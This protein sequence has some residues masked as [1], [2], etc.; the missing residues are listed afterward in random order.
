M[1]HRIGIGIV[2]VALVVVMSATSSFATWS[3][4]SSGSGSSV[5]R[6][7]GLPTAALATAAGSASITITWAAPTGASVTPTQYVVR[8]TA[9]S[10]A[11]VCTVGGGV[12]TCSDTGLSGGTTYTYTVE[13]RIG[14]N[15]TSGQT[16]GTS[17]T[18]TA[19]GNFLVSVSGTKTAGTA[20]SPTITATTNGVATDTSYA[21][22]KTITFSGP[23]AS[24]SGTNPTYPV[25]VTFTA[26]VG[27]PS[28]TLYNAAIATLSVTDGTISGSTS[29]TVTSG[30]ATQLG[31]TTSTPS[32][33]AGTVA[34]GN[35]G[36]FTSRVSVYDAYLN[37]FTQASNRT[38]TVSRSPII[39]TLSPTSLTIFTGASETST[40]ST[41][42]LPNGSPPNTT[43]TAAAAGLTSASCI[44]TK[45]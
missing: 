44:V 29:V 28:I 42:T 21:G 8:R 7:I 34:V 31:Y 38:I 3:P 12:F 33:A 16:A 36:S 35:A 45:T 18:T 6:S 41:F 4:G 9:P 26:G 22:V 32:C 10:T 14:T 20:F 40:A 5:G 27:T 11:T 24:P 37:P 13:A 2:I 17:A 23:L 30:S 25:N 1:K 43:V 15:W 19:A 39:G